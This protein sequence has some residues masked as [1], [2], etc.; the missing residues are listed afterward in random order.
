MAW[1]VYMLEC[2]GGRIYTGISPDVDARFVTHCAGK[3]GAFTR[4]FPPS[5]VLAAKPCRGRGSALKQE[6]ALKQLP[7]PEKE[8]WAAEWPWPS[9]CADRP[10]GSRRRR[11]GSASASGARRAKP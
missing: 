8:R 9:P 2:A 1:Y 5:R 10:A 7:R 3:G 11:S 6:Y 4:S